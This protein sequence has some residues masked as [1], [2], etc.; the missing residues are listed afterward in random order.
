MF[1][2]SPSIEIDEND[3]NSEDEPLDT[4][5]FG[6]INS[7]EMLK[8]DFNWKKP[9]ATVHRRTPTLTDRSDFSE[10]PMLFN[11]RIVYSMKDRISNPDFMTFV[12][13]PD[14]YKKRNLSIDVDFSEDD[15]KPKSFEETG[16]QPTG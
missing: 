10:A 5:K 2:T 11:I 3:I 9:G 8:N 6:F 4:P 14:A 12:I 1:W 7:D 13:I 16:I 15:T